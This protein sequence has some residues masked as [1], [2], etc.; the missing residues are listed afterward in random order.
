MREEYKDILYKNKTSHD[1]FNLTSA[2]CDL[3]GHSA[4]SSS[5]KITHGAEFLARWNTW[6]TARSLSP[7][8]C[9]TQ[10]NIV[11]C[12]YNTPHVNLEQLELTTNVHQELVVRKQ[13]ILILGQLKTQRKFFQSFL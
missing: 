2:L 13:I 5:K 6:R 8:Y 4:S 7:T 9:K 12:T 1:I 11:A 3:R 10:R